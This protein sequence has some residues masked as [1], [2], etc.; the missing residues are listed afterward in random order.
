M[1]R[2]LPPDRG[3]S[4][5]AAAAPW[6]CHTSSTPSRRTTAISARPSPS[7]SPRPGVPTSQPPVSLGQPAGRAP[8]RS[9]APSVYRPLPAIDLVD[10]VAVE[11]GDRRRDEE[12]QVRRHLREARQRVARAALPAH[13][14]VVVRQ[15]Q[16]GRLDVEQAG[17]A[18][19]RRGELGL[20]G[21]GVEPADREAGERGHRHDDVV[22][23]ALRPEARAS[24]RRGRRSTRRDVAPADLRRTRCGPSRR[25]R[26]AVPPR[27][28][29]RSRRPD[30]GS[31]RRLRPAS[32]RRRRSSA[33]P[34]ARADRASPA[35]RGG[36]PGRRDA[37][38]TD[39]GT[40]ASR[41]RRARSRTAG[42]CRGPPTPP[43]SA[44]TA[45]P[46]PM[47]GGSSYSSCAPTTI[48]GRPSPVR[49]TSVGVAISSPPSRTPESGVNVTLCDAGSTAATFA[50]I[51]DEHR[52]AG[53]RVPSSCHAYTWRS[54]AARDD[55]EAAV[56]VEVAAG[57]RAGE[58]GLGAVELVLRASSSRARTRIEV[59]G[60]R[61]PCRRRRSA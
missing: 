18:G 5:R 14:L 61:A 38:A 53:D 51:D 48:S 52:E 11:V 12:R 37:P 9:W 55:L 57:G 3:H 40:V 58:A 42:C 21:V 34:R 2:A 4:V 26:T 60:R 16:V 49:S 46:S 31:R 39:R 17:E 1:L 33:A 13:E 45:A 19:G 29:R 28:R 15:L 36:R 50:G 32:R 47:F 59:R 20:R 27:S 44:S 6:V 25:A 10:A 22:G 56:A 30:A 35:S 23:V 7:Q 8:A 24:R 43:S 41:P 54:S